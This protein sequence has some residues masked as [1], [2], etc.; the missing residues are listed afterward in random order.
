M[1]LFSDLIQTEEVPHQIAFTVVEVGGNVTLE[2]PV[3]GK[4]GKF[5]QW[6]K[7]RLGYEIQTVAT[8]TYNQQILS[9]QFN[10]QRFKVTEGKAHFAL[11]ITNVSKDDEATYFCRSGTAYS[12]SFIDTIFLAVNGKISYLLE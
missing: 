3:S 6:Y 7:L 8:G 10:N 11:T 9:A 12:Q 1:S 4:E 2:Y 5:F